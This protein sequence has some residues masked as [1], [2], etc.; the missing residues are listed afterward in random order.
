VLFDA[1]YVRDDLVAGCRRVGQ[2]LDVVRRALG[3]TAF[4]ALTKV[5]MSGSFPSSLKD[6]PTSLRILERDL[7]QAIVRGGWDVRYG[8]HASV[9]QRVPNIIANG[10]F[11]HV[12]VAHGDAWYFDR[13]A[14]KQ[15]SAGYITAARH[16][17]G[18]TTVWSGRST[19]WGTD[20]VERA[21]RGLLTDA[22]GRKL[23]TPG[24]WIGV[25]VSQHLSQQV[26]HP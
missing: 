25:R 14:T 1:G 11:P 13:A 16:L 3:R 4:D 15:N 5:C 6:I 21:S 2:A 24:P 9:H 12:D 18:D 20:M 10:W 23:T 8:D 22:D 7:H 19:S 26:L 17:V